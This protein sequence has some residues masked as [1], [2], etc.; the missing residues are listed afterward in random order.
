MC[1]YRYIYIYIYYIK[2]L[3]AG[4]YGR[5]GLIGL[6]HADFDQFSEKSIYHAGSWKGITGH[7]ISPYPTILI[8]VE[9]P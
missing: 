9:S 3:H 5:A 4:S 1:I 2:N 8:P 7:P 6:P